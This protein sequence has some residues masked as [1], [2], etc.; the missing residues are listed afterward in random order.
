VVGLLAMS[1]GTDDA[2]APST[3]A[4]PEELTAI[5]EPVLTVR[6]SSELAGTG[7]SDDLVASRLTAKL[8]CDATAH[9]GAVGP[10]QGYILKVTA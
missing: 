1:C 10:F 4:A 8:R 6:C 7:D 3:T 5:G 2:G 9:G